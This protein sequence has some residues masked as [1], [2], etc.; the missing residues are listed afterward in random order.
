MTTAADLA[1]QAAATARAIRTNTAG[2]SHYL[3]PID[4]VKGVQR[5]SAEL[6]CSLA[7]LAAQKGCLPDE[8]S[9]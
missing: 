8:L 9:E 2:W 6:A 1:K 4:A 3:P 7:A 5:L